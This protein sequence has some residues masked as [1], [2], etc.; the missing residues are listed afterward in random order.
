MTVYVDDWG[1]PATVR[2]GT[3]RHTS[4]WSHLFSDES[5]EELHALARRIGLRP[6]W[7]QDKDDHGLQ[8][9]RHYDVT[10]GKR[11][12]AIRAGAVPITWREAGQMSMEERRRRPRNPEKGLEGGSDGLV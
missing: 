11:F 5:D 3:R 6:E 12:A 2:N 4:K 1:Q 10:E 7:F 9:H 8:T